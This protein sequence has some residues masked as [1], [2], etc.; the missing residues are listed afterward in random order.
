MIAA[1]ERAGHSDFK[2]SSRASWLTAYEALPI[3]RDVAPI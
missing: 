1:T 2:S 3:A